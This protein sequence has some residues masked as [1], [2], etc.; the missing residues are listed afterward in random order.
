MK[1][2]YFSLNLIHQWVIIQW[3]ISLI[4]KL[5]VAWNTN[6]DI[7]RTQKYYKYIVTYYLYVIKWHKYR[8]TKFLT[9]WSFK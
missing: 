4:F 2:V 9:N 1:R 6:Y 7:L 8:I 5:N 3:K